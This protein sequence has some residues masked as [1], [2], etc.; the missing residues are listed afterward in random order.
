MYNGWEVV[1]M[2]VTTTPEMIDVALVLVMMWSMSEWD[3]LWNLVAL[4]IHQV[5]LF[6]SIVSR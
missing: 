5:K 4:S 3:E 6:L 2:S 1:L